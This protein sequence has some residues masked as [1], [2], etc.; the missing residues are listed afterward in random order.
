M[1]LSLSVLA[2]LYSLAC[3]VSCPLRHFW[4]HTGWMLPTKWTAIFSMTIGR[5]KRWQKS[6]VHGW[7]EMIIYRQ[8]A[9]AKQNMPRTVYKEN[10]CF[11]IVISAYIWH[12]PGHRRYLLLRRDR[13]RGKRKREREEKSRFKTGD[14][15]QPGP[16][17]ART[18][19]NSY[20]AVREAI[21]WQEKMKTSLPFW[22]GN[23]VCTTTLHYVLHYDEWL[24]QSSF[25][26]E[27]REAGSVA[28]PPY[29]LIRISLLSLA[30]AADRRP[31]GNVNGSRCLIYT[32]KYG[33]HNTIIESW[34]RKLVR[35]I[36]MEVWLIDG[37]I[38]MH[39][40]GINEDRV[41]YFSAEQ[42]FLWSRTKA[43]RTVE[44]VVEI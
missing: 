19:G 40:R 4:N 24:L 36:L 10:H 32:H 41:C 15:I 7:S 6:Y 14:Y 5:R 23:A 22:V 30:R 44:K 37:S 43:H 18:A 11:N 25:I 33:R 38:S 9:S 42:D 1:K 3:M 34:G 39:S 35:Q 12:N 20:A 8:N 13:V 29:T 31:S 16:R 21:A 2:L 17:R 28:P 26:A 27:E